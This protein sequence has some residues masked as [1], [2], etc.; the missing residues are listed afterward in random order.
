MKHM[1]LLTLLFLGCANETLVG[2]DAPSLDGYYVRSVTDVIEG[3]EG[4]QANFEFV[5]WWHFKQ[6]G[7]GVNNARVTGAEANAPSWRQPGATLWTSHGQFEYEGNRFDWLRLGGQSV[8]A[9]GERIELGQSGVEDIPIVV[10]DGYMIL[11]RRIYERMSL[12]QLESALEGG[13]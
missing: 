9:S 6:D 12:A 10:F 8:R 3:T 5:E 11:G 4:E 1:L 13:Q 2:S 7:T